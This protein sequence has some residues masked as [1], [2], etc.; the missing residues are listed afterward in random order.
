M[1][2]GVLPSRT[3]CFCKVNNYVGYSLELGGL[4]PD[5]NS[6]NDLILGFSPTK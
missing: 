4:I 2:L 6:K 5:R 3:L 1:M